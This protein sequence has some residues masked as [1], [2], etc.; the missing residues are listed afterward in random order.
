[1]SDESPK[2]PSTSDNILNTEINYISNAKIRVKFDGSCLKQE[3]LTFTDKAILN[4]CIF[5]EIS[6]WPPNKVSKITLLS[7]LFDAVN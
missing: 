3:K 2:S 7:Y 5:S 6:L 4:F 1:M